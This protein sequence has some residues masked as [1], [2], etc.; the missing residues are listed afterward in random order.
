MVCKKRFWKRIFSWVSILSILFNSVLPYY[1]LV[2]PAYAQESTASATQQ[3]IDPTPTPTDTPTPSP[4]D[5]PTP[6]P[7]LDPMP[8][9]TPSATP[10]PTLEPTPE[11]TPSATPTP[12]Q[13]EI[14]DGIATESASLSEAKIPLRMTGDFLKK[15]KTQAKKNYVEGEVIVKFRKEKLDI[16]GVFGKAQAFVF[17]KKFSLEKRDEIKASNI[18]VFKSKKSTEE[19]VK[20]LKSDS[21]VEYAQPNYI[22]EPTSIGTNDT[23]KDLLWGLENTSQTVNGTSGTNDTDIDGPEAWG[24]SEGNGTIVAV[25]DSGVAYNHPDLINSMWNGS[26]CKDENGSVLGGCNSGYDYEDGDKIPLPSTS[27]HGTHIA[28]TIAAVKNNS[29][30][31]IGVAPQTKIMAIKFDYTSTSAIKGINFAKENGAT[32]I[33]ASW[34]GT[35]EDILLKNAISTFPG[36]FIAAAGNEGTNN[37]SSHKYPCDYDSANIIC[38]AAT[39]QNDQLATWTTSGGSNYSSTFVDVGAPGKNIYSTGFLT[40]DFTNASLPGFTNTIFT[41]TSGGWKTG[42]WGDVGGNVSDKNAQANSSYINNDTSILTLTSPK[43]E[44]VI[45]TNVLLTFYLYLDA[46]PSSGGFCYD[47]LAVETDNND[48]NWVTKPGVYCG[49]GAGWVTFDLGPATS[50]MRTRF[51]WHT[52]G[53]V[54]GTQVPIIDDIEFTNTLSY[55]YMDG[56]SMAAPH[57]AGLAALI[58][59]YNPSLTVAQVKDKILTTGDTLPVAADAA[60][61]LSG[62]RINAQKALQAANSAKAIT[63]FTVP[64]QTG[65]TVINESAHTIGITVPF[66]TN[67]TA[68]VPTIT[69]TGVS[70]NPA[71]GVAQNFTNPVTYTVTAADSST[72]AYTVTVTVSADPVATA[73]DEISASLAASPNN[74]ANNLND[75]T[76]ANVG[77]FSGLYFEKSINGTPV[78]KLTFTGA[79]NLSSTET[80]TF[81]QNLGAKLDQGEGRIALNATESAV[82]AAAGATLVMYDMLAVSEANLIVRDDAGII[83]DPTGIVSGFIQA[84]PSGNITFN[85][86]H[87]TQFDIDT[88]SPVITDHAAVTAEATSVSG[89]TITYDPPIATDNIDPVAPASCT[90]ASGST[91]SIGT[92]TVTCT[93][94]DTAG[95]AA[96]PTTFTVNVQDTTKPTNVT[97]SDSG[98]FTNNPHLVFTWPASS[99]SGSGVNYYKF[100]LNTAESHSTPTPLIN[101]V[102]IG[103]V[104]TYTLSDAQAALLSEGT[105]YYA[106]VRAVDNVGLSQG[107]AGN[108]SDGITLDTIAPAVNIT[109]PVT[110]D[111]V[112]GT[113]VITF[114]DNENTAPQCSIDNSTFVACTS[115]VTTLHDITG[116]DAL[117]E[118]NFTLYLKDTDSATNTGATNQGNIVKDTTAPALSSVGIS[119]NNTT[120]TLAKVGDT[121]TLHFFSSEP[122]KPPTVYIAGHHLSETDITNNVPINGNEWF[123]SYQMVEGDSEGQVGLSISYVDAVDN[124]G[125]TVTGTTDNSNVT[126]DKTKP[127]I[128][129]HD[130]IFATATSEDGAVV[131]YISPSATDYVD[132]TADAAC[133]PASGSTFP[134]GETTVNCTKTDTAGNTA[135]PTSFTVTVTTNTP[136]SFDAI[137]SPVIDEDS[138][139]QEVSITNISA[140]PAGEAGQTVVMSATSSDTVIVPNP[141]V[142]GSGATRTLTYTPAANKY[143]SATITVTADDGQTLNNTYSRMF[144]IV[145][146]SVNDAPVAIDDTATVSEDATLSIAKTDLVSNDTDV[147]STSLTLT[148]VSNPTHGTV[149]IV[150]SNAVFIP[151]ADYSGPASF[152]YTVSDGS[153][154]DTGT[155]AVTVN[156]I[157]DA[158]VA[159]DASVSATEETPVVITLAG[160][161]IDGN[162]LTYSIIDSPVNGILSE[163][164]ENQVTYT[165]SSNY[166]G[167]DSFTYKANDGTADSN[168]AT[169]SIT[170]SEYNDPPVL[171][172]IGDKSVNE[173]ATLSFTAT[174]TDPDNTPTYSLTNAPTGATINLTTGVFS[175]TPTEAQGLGTYTLTVNA[176]DGTSTDSEEITITVNEVNVAPVA[177]DVSISTLE[178]TTKNITLSATDIDL[179]EQGINYSLVTNPTHG[180]V[181][182]I[183]DGKIN[184]TPSSDYNGADSF[185]Y[186]VND[187]NADSNTA[188]VTI[189]V[190]AVNDAPLANPDSVFTNEDETLTIAKSDLLSNDSDVDSI[191]LTL[192]AVSNPTNGTVSIVGSDV[193]FIPTANYSGDASFDYTASDGTSTSTTTVSITVDPVNDA[194]VVNNSSVTTNEDES[195]TINL[196]G[197]DIDGDSLTYSIAPGVSHGTLDDISISGNQ[198]TY[199]PAANYS[200]SDSFTFSASDGTIDSAP[201]TV[202]IT[203]TAT[204]DAPAASN[205]TASVNED[206][207]LTIAKSVL[208]ANDTDVDGNFLTV[209]AVSNSTHGT[210]SIIGSNVVFIPIADYFGP[211]S[212]DYT[213]SDGLLTDTVTVS[214]TVN[215]VND[216]PVATNGASTTDQDVAKVIT[217]GASDSDIPVQTLTYFVVANPSHGTLSAAL[218]NQITY[219]P[220]AHYSGTDSFTFKANDGIDDSNTA[221]INI[222]INDTSA[223]TVTKLGDGST[224]VI[225]EAGDMDLIFSEVLSASS[226]TAVENALTSGADNTLTY[227]W[228]GATLTITATETT[229]FAND[230]VVNVSDLAGNTATSL[231]L[232][233]SSLTTT[234]TT[235]DDD[236]AATADSDSPE[237]VITDPDQEVTVTVDGTTDA[238]IDVSSFIDGGTGDV[239]QITI[240]SDTADIAIPATT[241][242]GPADWNGVIAAPTVTTV[243]LPVTTGETTTLG[244]AIEIGFANAKLSFDNAVRILLP[245]QAG[246]RAGYSRP[247]TEFTE[248]T[249]AC[250]TDSQVAGDALVADGECKIDVGGDLVIWTKHFTKFASYTQTTNSSSSSNSSSSDSGSSAPV[251]NDTTPVGVPTILRVTPGLNSATLVWNEGTGPLSYYLITF[252]T[253]P[254][255]Q[256]YGNPNIGGAGTTSY[257]VN[258]LSGG[259]RY[260]F[261]VRSGN[262]CAPG[263]FSNEVSAVPLGELAQELPVGF[264]ENV[265]G[266]QTPTEELSSSPTPQAE[267]VLGS[268]KT[269]NDWKIWLWGFIP[270]SLLLSLWLIFAKK[271]KKDVGQY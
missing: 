165:P 121:V 110:G 158:P 128:D 155:V 270:V 20:E 161:D 4:T 63:A 265:L 11:A 233:D 221:S 126:F 264:A 118:D 42:T 54:I 78:G 207:T 111:T 23:Y 120:P 187:G 136:P 104:T 263:G 17:E 14:L 242:T 223:P 62:K 156:P 29:K 255:A 122:I 159:N 250:S 236:G 163:V 109:S 113:K 56:T 94:T 184:Y 69:T 141:S 237:V 172:P 166:T 15:S 50:D 251:C 225:L 105:T 19:M 140:G 53:S 268:E 227:S 96:V 10:E 52:N 152:D 203:V 247:G 48:N 244:T 28:G 35:S 26:S 253:Q 132:A 176:T 32:I 116:F 269:R 88:T 112:N 189:T 164:S 133:T 100:Y 224:D 67:V 204:N 235:P 191:S 208:L 192:T 195:V 199:T 185:I 65:S 200:G 103:N 40:D 7:T 179:P 246:K 83:L 124:A 230:V 61:I 256:T 72:Q 86:A 71:S 74:V 243:T 75:V 34:G 127:V 157:N 43:E 76:T 106:K 134:I 211:A 260:Y 6:T 186:K 217:L 196:S 173:L 229:T 210:V 174:A 153:L 66:G 9:A 47:Y 178:D 31:I 36:L 25:I 77:S 162:T 12:E 249:S 143:G 198:M 169:V 138:A 60:K 206:T 262:G 81:L 254:G 205:D 170:V 188:T 183:I 101:G 149:S 241:V 216:K 84:T 238:T 175:F 231:L 21:N 190:N 181:D 38:V 201:A 232:V 212:F 125:S 261:K 3:I 51:V 85:T 68:L 137:A 45:G 46:E 108:W 131:T 147:D 95:N 167:P 97:V 79:L 218:E 98:T 91:F 239:P 2:T 151:T 252:G 213:V 27:S 266:V 259:T 177:N 39:D 55:Q 234:Q 135:T 139:S 180:T 37:D 16:K 1:G 146:N 114:T 93:K 30:G 107:S 59:G 115:G 18:Q 24:T 197:S 82:F 119:S 194:P 144:T 258:S 92:N 49:G 13:G 257:T 41:K 193:V 226:K 117:A 214:I 148:A 80:Q 99:D 222:I 215:S 150:E 160:T 70:V 87:F 182:D 89:A 123:A 171:D 267:Q 248:I 73:F 5:T 209:T 240:N 64:G 154:T 22:Y 202:S 33:N 245:G 58:E 220:N 271:R 129:D 145:V 142:S 168:S 57:V 8:T 90:P 102:N 130:N 228:T 219:T 44:S